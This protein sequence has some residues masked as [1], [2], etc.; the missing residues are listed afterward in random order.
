[1]LVVNLE[2]TVELNPTSVGSCLASGSMGKFEGRGTFSI[3]RRADFSM[4]A[5]CALR[6][7]N[8]RQTAWNW[9]FIGGYHG[10]ENGLGSQTQ[11]SRDLAIR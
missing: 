2:S 6:K 7:G 4:Y 5:S 8:F 9:R 10:K 3:F 11:T 1:M